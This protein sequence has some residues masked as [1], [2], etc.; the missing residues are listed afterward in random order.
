MLA[1]YIQPNQ[2]FI[3]CPNQDVVYAAGFAALDNLPQIG[4]VRWGCVLMD[5]TV[6]QPPSEPKA[7]QR[8]TGPC[9]LLGELRTFYHLFRR[10]CKG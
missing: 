10:T 9:R 5:L 8:S 3:V 7:T 4:Q 2:N 6:L 1:D